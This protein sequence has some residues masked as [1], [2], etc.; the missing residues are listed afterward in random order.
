MSSQRYER[1]RLRQHSLPTS[2]ATPSAPSLTSL[3]LQV[4]INDDDDHT[5][6]ESQHSS[7][8]RSPPPSFHSRTSSLGSARRRSDFEN[9]RLISDND[10]T[11]AD[12]F[13]SPSDDESDDGGS[14]SL[15]DRQRAMS[16]RPSEPS[17]N[18]G[19]ITG[20]GRP[21][22]VERRVTQLP[23]F[24]PPSSN[25]VYGGGNAVH[26][27]VFANLNAKPERGGEDPE[28]KPPVCALST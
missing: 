26:D 25:K 13:D 11:L 10:R 24:A 7:H 27:G 19:Q 20:N 2:K 23:V 17:S 6:A 3:M 16:G 21:R 8:D 28:E 15:D 4:S 22:A 14:H 9:E 1:V 5:D 12:T 18:M